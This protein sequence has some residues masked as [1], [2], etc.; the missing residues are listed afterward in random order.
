MRLID[1]EY[2]KR[3]CV[4]QRFADSNFMCSLP[5]TKGAFKDLV[6]KMVDSAPTIDAA[7][8]K[9]GH[10]IFVKRTV[11]VPT[12]TIVVKRTLLSPFSPLIDGE[13]LKI[14][15]SRYYV[16]KKRKSI[17]KPFCSECR[18]HGDNEFDAT[19]FCPNCGAIMDGKPVVIIK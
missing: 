3:L 14:P 7:P 19:P 1:A 18:D 9:H 11:L 15:P 2:I 4:P 13:W 6:N 10:W 5:I 16:T 8:V 12:K 17:L